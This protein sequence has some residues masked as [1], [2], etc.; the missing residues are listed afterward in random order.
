MTNHPDYASLKATI[1]SCEAASRLGTSALKAELGEVQTAMKGLSALCAGHT[2]PVHGSVEVS[3]FDASFRVGRLFSFVCLEQ[4][5]RLGHHPTSLH[6]SAQSQSPTL[7]AAVVRTVCAAAAMRVAS[8]GA[9][10]MAV[11][12]T[13][14]GAGVLLQGRMV[15]FQEEASKQVET[16]ALHLAEVEQELAQV[17]VVRGK[18]S[19]TCLAVPDRYH[20][21]RSHPDLSG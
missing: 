5:T 7:I 19:G 18:G 12:A 13:S 4:G 17:S 2:G 20:S 15:R 1:P 16:L 9:C 6:L 10:R 21:C 3:T 11:N 8:S 14:L